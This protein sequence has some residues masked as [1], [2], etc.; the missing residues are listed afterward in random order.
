MNASVLRQ[1]LNTCLLGATENWYT[2][3]LAH[4]SRIGLRNDTN[5]VKEWCNTLEARFR[6]SLSKSLA[7]LEAIRYTV[8][9]ARLRRDPL[10]YVSTLVLHAKNAGIA[11]TEAAQVLLVYKHIDGE[12]RRDLPRPQDNSTIS[13]LLE[14][15]R[16]Q[17]DIWFDIYG[18][19]DT[20]IA[21][22][23]TR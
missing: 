5:G 22:L 4:L 7:A 19:H 20:R 13:G 1:N 18:T 14:E 11:A 16:H 10:D 15:L 2:N 23:S 6:D 21:T 8:R 17:K 9:D 3:E 12:L